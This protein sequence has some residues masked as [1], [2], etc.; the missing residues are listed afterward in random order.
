MRFLSYCLITGII[1]SVT[2]GAVGCGVSTTA[3]TPSTTNSPAG[4][5][6]SIVVTPAS[7]DD[8]ALGTTLQLKATGTYS[9]GSTLIISSR[10]TWT[11]TDPKI[12]TVSPL[13]VVTSAATGNTG[14]TASLSGMSSNVI[15]LTVSA[16]TL[17]SIEVTFDSFN[18]LAVGATQQFTA[19]GTYSDS[20]TQDITSEVTWASS[21]PDI[22]AISDAGLAKGLADGKT[23]I[24]ASLSGVTAKAVTLPIA[25]LSSVAI[26]QSPPD[27]LTVGITQQFT[28][29][30]IYS[31]GTTEYL[32]S[33][34]TW[35]SSDIKI[36]SISSLGIA[37]G[38][39]VGTTNITA[40]VPGAEVTSPAVSLKVVAPVL[41]TIA[42]TPKSPDTLAAGLSL[43]FKATGIY[44]DNS[45]Q[46]ITSQVTWAN[47]SP[48][49]T[50]ISTTG[51]AKA[52][53]AG[54]SNIT[55]SLSGVTSPAAILSVAV[56]S[57]IAVAPAAP[58][59]L[60]VGSTLAFRAIA[61]YSDKSV[62]LISSGLTWTSS[63]TNIATI[64]PDGVA[65]GKAV[66]TTNITVTWSG[67]GV[68]SPAVTLNVAIT[69][70]TTATP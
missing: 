63:D 16:P 51:L 29:K 34:V 31:D 45:T 67:L 69:T 4:T 3:T 61:T 1:V 40:A 8:L 68:T 41:T 30:G 15:N 36:A 5:L 13:G 44:S 60:T 28:V 22:A 27:D 32:T 65:A 20:S 64:T 21:S 14:I 17:S 57:S 42:I 2:L 10:V 50:S 62:A 23:D 43:Q 37:T 38:I 66:G 47:S 46:D 48:G 58:A 7:P 39:A 11:S 49:I 70:S 54:N 18:N 19:T 53:T 9:N 33:N 55:A 52:I 6:S 24:T 12:A 25:T 56:L 59:N 35:S 26:T